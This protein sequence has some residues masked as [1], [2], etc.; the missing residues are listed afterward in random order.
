MTS[1]SEVLEGTREKWLERIRQGIRETFGECVVAT[2][3]D[4]RDVRALHVLINKFNSTP[5]LRP[6]GSKDVTLTYDSVNASPSSRRLLASFVDSCEKSDRACCKCGRKV[7]AYSEVNWKHLRSIE[8]LD[9]IL[10]HNYSESTTSAD[11]IG[12]Q[13]RG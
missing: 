5:H 10:S 8:K 4:V 13:C 2:C 3:I 9:R 1:V 12:M 11:G 7:R 6:S